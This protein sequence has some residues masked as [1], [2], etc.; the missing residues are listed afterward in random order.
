MSKVLIVDDDAEIRGL[1]CKVME[2]KGHK[3]VSGE[4]G[5]IG[6][7][8]A[9]AESPNLIIMDLNMPVMDGFRATAAIKANPATKN[10]PVLIL[11]AEHAET[12]RE[13]MYEAG[14]DGFVPKPIDLNRLFARASEFLK[15]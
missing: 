15:D 8:L 6:T 5:Q 13:A 3:V 7:E 11:S 1:L 10:I 4:N 2:S 9:E 12:N 14:C